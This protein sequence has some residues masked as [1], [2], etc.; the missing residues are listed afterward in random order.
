MEEFKR[1]EETV[2]EEVVRTGGEVRIIFATGYQTMA[3]VL[4]FDCENILAVVNGK[5]W[6]IYRQGVSTIEII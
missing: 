5:N 2:L 4:D 6:L 3:K 1:L